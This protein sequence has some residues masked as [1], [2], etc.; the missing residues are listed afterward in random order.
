[1]PKSKKNRNGT[2][3]TVRVPNECVD[4]VRSLA[5]VKRVST[6]DVYREIF[7]EWVEYKRMKYDCGINGI[8]SYRSL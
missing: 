4:L 7:R 2:T 3:E 5:K 8:W 6:N 1:M